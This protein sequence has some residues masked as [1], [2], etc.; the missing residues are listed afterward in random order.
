M[1]P[2]HRALPMAA[3]LIT[4]SAAHADGL[5]GI[6]ALG[7][8]GP[9]A[10]AEPYGNN[11]AVDPDF[12]G[13]FDV[14]DGSVGV[15]GLGTVLANGLRIEGRFAVR[16]SDINARR[17]GTGARAGE[18]YI[19]DGSVQS[20]SFTLETLYEF[21]GGGTFT[22]Y[23]K[24]GIGVSDNDFDARLGGA[25]VAGFDAVDGTVDGFYDAYPDGSSTEFSWT[26]G[27][28]GSLALGPNSVLFGEV[29]YLELGQVQT[30]QDAFTD[31]FGVDA[32]VTEVLVGL[33]LS[34]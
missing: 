27:L 26:L 3:L 20:T 4:A 30:A 24:A 22:P 23:V 12:P 29:Q 6:G 15:I 17:I 9:N 21:A 11:I 2:T 8:S 13:A 31:G 16:D 18:E 32:A 33:R 14:D 19:L 7:W 25:G 28:G 1:S 10:D 34:F 5:Y